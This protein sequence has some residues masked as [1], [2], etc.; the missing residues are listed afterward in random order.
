[1]VISQSTYTT[2]IFIF[3]RFLLLYV[4]SD[5]MCLDR[6]NYVIIIESYAKRLGAGLAL[7][8]G[9]LPTKILKQ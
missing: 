4:N 2:F 5:H 9:E 3:V 8:I 1:M 6:S 7:S